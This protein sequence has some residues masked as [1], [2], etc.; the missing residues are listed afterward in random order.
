MNVY[1][2]V[3]KVAPSNLEYD[4]FGDRFF[5]EVMNLKMRLLVWA[6]IQYGQRPYKEMTIQKYGG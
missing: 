2:Y 6:I 4:L 1:P 5:K 3:Y